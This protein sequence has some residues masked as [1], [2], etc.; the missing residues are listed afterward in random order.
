MLIKLELKKVTKSF[1]K[2]SANENGII[3]TVYVSKDKLL[4]DAGALEVD[5]K[6]PGE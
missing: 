3:I 1:F 4:P 6:L 2:F 5:V